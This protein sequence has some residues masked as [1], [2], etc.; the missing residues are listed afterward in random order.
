LHK[1]AQ[2]VC[3]EFTGVFPDNLEV[4]Q[5]LP[6]IGRSTAAAILS[7][8]GNQKQAILD[9][10]VKRVISRVFAIEGWPGKADVLKK[11]WGVVEKLVPNQR[12]ADYTQAIMDLGATLCRRTKPQ[13]QKC[14][15]ISDCLAFKDDAIE[16]YPGKKP[17]KVLPEKYAVMLII[18]DQ[19]KAVFM[20]KRPPTG[21]WGGLWCFPQFETKTEANEWLQGYFSLELAELN[22]VKQEEQEPLI[23]VFSHFRLTIQ[24]VI[25]HLD[26]RA[27]PALKQRVMETDESLWYN[28]DTEFNGGLASP[29][30]TLLNKLKD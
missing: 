23:H 9:G 18:Q 24:P 22:R 29:V 6:G 3:D 25:I 2:R 16:R 11:M 26:E 27:N 28:I 8:S 7:I 19:N 17:K 10:N 20:Q 5:S 14:P 12:N 30:Q 1:T 13:C 15:F 21:I 4:M